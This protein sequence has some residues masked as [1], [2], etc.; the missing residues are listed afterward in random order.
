MNTALNELF[1]ELVPAQGKAENLAGEIVRAV[2][3]IGYRFFNDGDR[4]NV[5][6]G[7]ETCNP[8][9]RF[10]SKKAP[11]AIAVRSDRLWDSRMSEEDYEI[12]LD[13][14]VQVTYDIITAHPE[15]K[16]QETCDMW[17]YFDQYED[18]DDSLD[19]EEEEYEEYEEEEEEYDE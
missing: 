3:R 9:A 11:D 8:A 17:D 19:D 7:K 14:L 16:Q 2:S 6:Y 4:V 15:M 5:G 12:A 18:R 1:D 13:D 10:L